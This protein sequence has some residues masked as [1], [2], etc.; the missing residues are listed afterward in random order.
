MTLDHPIGE[1]FCLLHCYGVIVTD[2]LSVE[3]H[4]D[5][6]LGGTTLTTFNVAA[7]VAVSLH[8]A[9]IIEIGVARSSWVGACLLGVFSVVVFVYLDVRSL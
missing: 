9:N 8:R 6:K 2:V 1:L 7:V 3:C 5:P 4:P